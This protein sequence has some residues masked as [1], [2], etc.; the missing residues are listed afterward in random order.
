MT[1]SKQVETSCIEANQW[2]P[3]IFL[4]LQELNLFGLLGGAR[5]GFPAFSEFAQQ[6]V[7]GWL[8]V[9][10]MHLSDQST[11]LLTLLPAFLSS[12]NLVYFFL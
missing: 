10:K 3:G 9:A 1:E 5:P 7:G 8:V 12:A 2:K 6:L 11:S 4:V